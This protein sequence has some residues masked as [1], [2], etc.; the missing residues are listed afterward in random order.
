MPESKV[1]ITGF[2]ARHYDKLLN[3]IS[4]GSYALFIRKAIAA[5]EIQ[6]SDHILDFG[7]GTGRN[8]CLMAKYLSEE[9]RVTGLDIGEEMIR[10]FQKKCRRYPNFSVRNAH[11][12]EPLQ[13]A[14][15]YD[16]VFFSFVFHGFQ[17][18]K[19]EVILDNAQKALKPG[20]KL[21]ILDYNEF[22]INQKSPVF[23]WA[24]KKF[25]CSLAL[26]Y[27]KVDWKARLAERGFHDF[28]QHL[29]YGK[30]VRL[31]RATL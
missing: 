13:A 5:M 17:D 14:T 20:G 15:T 3:L 16:K 22:D 1:E 30:I 24:F 6:P 2:E 18:E 31:L 9:G 7:C 11:I 28:E 4:L 12:D 8:A 10:Q 19:K 21:F 23:R 27:L 26:D 25:E 29:F